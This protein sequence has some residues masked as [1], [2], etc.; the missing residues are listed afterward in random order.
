MKKILFTFIAFLMLLHTNAQ[1]SIF[2]DLLQ[3]H[4]SDKGIV[5]YQ[6]FKKDEAK[7]DSYIKYLGKTTPES[8]WSKDKEK[9]FW[10]NAYNAYTI[11]LILEVKTLYVIR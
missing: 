2:N 6:S 1:T 8:T 11:K 3:K 9:A 10:I 7:L 5:D 4:V